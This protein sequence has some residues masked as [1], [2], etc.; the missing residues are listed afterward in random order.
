MYSRSGSRITCDEENRKIKGYDIV[1]NYKHN[2]SNI[3]KYEIKSGDEIN[4]AMTYEHNGKIFVVNRGVIVK[5]KTTNEKSLQSFHYCSTCSKWLY[6]STVADHYEKCP[7][8]ERTQV[9]IHKD[10][11]L[12]IEG[13]QDVVSFEFLLATDVD[14]ISYYTTLKETIL[15]SLMLTYNLDESDINGFINPI[16]GKKEHSIV[17]F[18]TEEG[19]TGVLKSLLNTSTTQFEKFIENMFLILHI[20]SLEPYDE[21]MDAC[22]TACYN[23]LLRFRNQFEHKFLKRKLILPLMLKID[24]AILS[25]AENQNIE[26]LSDRLDNLK[27]KCDSELE[28]DVLDAIVKLKLPLP[29]KAQ[30]TFYLDGAPIAKADFFYSPNKYIFV[31]GPPHAPENIREEDKIKRDKLDSKGNIIIELDFIDGKYDEDPS[32]IEKEVKKEFDRL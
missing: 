12:F 1:I 7:K 24:K 13:N 4:G 23:C 14:A 19:G 2:L 31:D 11:W 22:I 26:S 29:D 6:E 21:T 18:E 32:L 5:S 15:Q 30:E 20:K 16:H 28:K 3:S 8:K 27:S 25:P 10:L 17:I 9:N